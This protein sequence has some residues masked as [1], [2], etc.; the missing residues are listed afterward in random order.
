MELQY[1]IF[2]SES[3]KD[4]DVL[5]SVDELKTIDENHKLIKTWNEILEKRFVEQGM[6]LKKVNC[7]LGIF[8]DQQITKVFKGTYD[9]VNN[10]LY[11]TY[12]N[13]KQYFNNMVVKP[14]DRTTDNFFKHLKLKRCYR[15]L[16]SF[17]S[18]VPELREQIKLALKGD[19]IKRHEVLSKINFIIHCEFP[20]KK[21]SEEDI[22]KVIAFQL[23]Q[24]IALFDNIEIYSKEQVLEH[25]PALENPI[26][27]RGL[28]SYDLVYLNQL[29]YS[30][31]SIGQREIP[32][33]KDLNEEIFN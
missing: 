17:Y 21:D 30:L 3:S 32:L 11:Y 1:Q 13:H 23:A 27:R 4:Y 16:L 29:L 18:R 25:Y 20:K 2:G 6:P 10:S 12:N 9:E 22:Y 7:N 19:F 14:Y 5:L 8:D 24:T 33:M 15:F 28:V 26:L 31:L